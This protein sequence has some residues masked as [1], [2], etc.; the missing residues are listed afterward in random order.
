M[1]GKLAR[2]VSIIGVGITKFGDLD[3]PETPQLKD[4]SLQDMAAWAC[5]EAMRD[6]GVR[7]TQIDKLVVGEVC[8]TDGDAD[9]ISPNFGLGNFLGMRGKPTSFQSEGCATPFDALN[10]AIMEVASGAYDIAM[11]VD[12]DSSRHIGAPDQPSHIRYAKNQYKKIFGRE[13]PT[14]GSC[15]DTAYGRWV[16]GSSFDS[17]GRR[18][19]R[20]S[21]IS[22]EDFDD[23]LAGYAI[24]QRHHAE[25]NPK[26]YASTP[27]EEIAKAR[28]FDD[29]HDYLRSRYTPKITEYLRTATFALLSEGAAA[30]IVC[31]TERAN[32]F[33]Q[34]PIEVVDLVQVDLGYGEPEA[35]CTMNRE[36]AKKLWEQ[37]D[38]GPE[39]VQYFQTTDGDPQDALDSAESFGYLPKGE[40]WRYFRDGLTRFDGPK[41]MCCDG[42]HLTY[43]HAFGAT[44]LATIGEC[45]YQMR[46]QAGAR[47]IATPPTVSL[48]RGWGAYQSET[49][50]LF[51]T[52]D[53]DKKTPTAIDEPYE[54]E[55]IVKGFYDGLEQGKFLARRCK[56]CGAIQ[57]PAFPVCS[58][59]GSYETEW[60]ELSGDVTVE[61][62]YEVGA[63]FTMP[64][65]QP[66]APV[67]GC[68]ATLAEGPHI[69]CYVFGV[70][71]E[72]F[73]ELRDKVPIKAR[74]CTLPKRGYSVY[75]VGI[76]GAVPVAHEIGDTSAADALRSGH[77]NEKE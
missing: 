17:I 1:A 11:V 44:A 53:T 62:I 40:G 15:Q 47:Q 32:E 48:M 2:S 35:T 75:A 27:W 74:L 31:A 58:S 34:K 39:D 28:G 61:E 46:G 20:E 14:G 29:V 10:E 64:D 26:T 71:P 76:N 67:Y 49:A 54:M 13:P 45:V 22:A 8:A 18:Y 73:G 60:C 57:F 25:L 30:I 56:K 7:S 5:I 16:G 72:N 12:T 63:A 65:M 37:S 50:Y 52:V 42:G 66:Y 69:Q 9:S 51:R 77:L 55:N 38:Y 23:A 59:C 70:T 33:R 4:K 24:T 36:L 21:G 68:E 3:D 6:A 19:I 43:G 41:P